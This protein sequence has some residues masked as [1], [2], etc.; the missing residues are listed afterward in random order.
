MR[1]LM[2]SSEFPP[3]PGGIG[4]HAHQLA[5]RLTQSGWRVL[6]ATAQDYASQDEVRA[7]NAAQPFQVMRLR[8]VP[9][10][11]LEA[12]YRWA[13]V[14][15]L[16]GRFGPD[17]I[18]ATGARFVWLA[19]TLTRTSG[20]PW[21]AV[22]HGGEF[23]ARSGWTPRLTRWSFGRATAVVTVSRYTLSQGEALGVRARLAR[24]IPNGADADRFRAI[25]ER[26]VAA[27]REKE[28]LTG[29]SIV[30]SVGNVTPRK[31]QD[32]VIRALPEILKRAPGTLYVIVGLPTRRAELLELARSLGVADRVRFVGK[33]SEEDLVLYFNV[34]DVFAMTSRHTDDGG[35]EGYGIAVVEAALCGKPAVVSQNS[36]LVEAIVAGKTGF[37]VP[38]G[39]E[40]A[41]ARAILDLLENT[42]LR[43]EMGDAARER[44]LSDQTWERRAA[45]YDRLLR[46]LAPRPRAL[47]GA[48][49]REEARPGLG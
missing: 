38:E 37:A 41:T 5:S 21:I 14:S 10:P 27:F 22:G 32:V 48:A 24:V 36:G 29:A 34:C 7:F 39:D 49:G 11:P 23:G 42:E 43:T 28:G 8:A 19:A 18:L 6:I 4:T 31:G 46:S 12:L 33:V 30:L 35:F 1:L 15:R 13:T 44:A 9:F 17:A 40:A 25:P 26:E 2:L 3:G 16:I 20:V 47:E 45:E